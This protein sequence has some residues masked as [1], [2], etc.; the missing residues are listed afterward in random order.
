M[1]HAEVKRL[2]QAKHNQGIAM[3][4]VVLSAA[5]FL[6]ILL[7]VTTTL[8]ISSRRTTSDQRVTLEA[9]YASES[10]L[11]RVLNEINATTPQGDLRA[12]A[13]LI[14]SVNMS[15]I[16]ATALAQ[17]A[18]QFC[19]Y[20][21]TTDVPNHTT[22]LASV[23]STGFCT[24]NTDP[25]L[26]NRFAFLSAN[27]PT[28]SYATYLGASTF[29]VGGTAPTDTASAET[30]WQ[31][32]FDKGVGVKHSSVLNSSDTTSSYDVQFGLVPDR[33]DVSSSG[34]QFNFVFKPS[35]IR[36]I[37]RVAN[38]AT[39]LGERTST[40][41]LDGEFQIQVQPASFSFY[42]LLTD[43]Q[44]TGGPSGND[45]YF[46]SDTLYDGP[47]HTNGHFNYTGKPWFASN[48]T[49]AGCPNGYA[50][51]ANGQC[52]TPTAGAN[53]FNSGAA[54]FLNGNP[55]DFDGQGS[56]SFPQTVR[57]NPTSPP[58]TTAS[59]YTY[60]GKYDNRAIP[61]PSDSDRQKLAA[62]GLA[63]SAT[64]PVTGSGIYIPVVKTSPTPGQTTDLNRIYMAAVKSDGTPIAANP[65]GRAASAYQFIR[66]TRQQLLSNC[67]AKPTLTMTPSTPTPIYT[68]NSLSISVAVA[69]TT[70]TYT[71]AAAVQ[72]VTWS[73]PAGL[74]TLTGST[75]LT[76]TYKASAVPTVATVQATHQY[77]LSESKTLTITVT[78]APPPAPTPPT[79]PGLPTPP[80]PPTPPPPGP[81][82]TP[83]PPTPPSP[84]ASPPG[85]P[86]AGTCLYGPAVEYKWPM[87]DEY[88]SYKS[89]SQ[90]VLQKRTYPDTDAT[91]DNAMVRPAF[92][93]ASTWTNDTSDFN[94][95]IYVDGDNI[96]QIR[97]PSRGTATNP[98][99]ASPAVASF[100]KLNIVATGSIGIYN[101]L[102]YEKP[103]CYA[104]GSR[105]SYAVRN[106]D[107]S[108]TSAFCDDPKSPSLADN[109]LGIY[110]AGNNSDVKILR[111][112]QYQDFTINAVLMSAKG[113]VLV[114]GADAAT[115][116]T[117][118]A[119]G[120][121]SIR[122][123]GGIIQ[124][125]YGMW[126]RANASGNVDCG[127]GR[128]ITYD[129]RMASPLIT[130]PAFPTTSGASAL[131]VQ[132][133]RKG[134]S[135]QP[136]QQIDTSGTTVNSVLPVTI[137]AKQTTP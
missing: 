14:S 112:T 11:S 48:L 21:N 116:P 113:R 27:V 74:G 35:P 25:N 82:P 50:P 4:V 5:V 100:A 111:N 105:Q 97:G 109:I 53:V 95:V 137:G 115:C 8:S 120:R 1:I 67:P 54:A 121:G 88:R 93:D 24:P 32:V 104:S 125:N 132:F 37:G 71:E 119:G 42:A 38:G 84:P 128:S 90:M 107:N 7:A 39:V 22:S 79:P 31:A 76:T 86:I 12:W 16:D 63:T 58:A 51:T 72:Q 78:V 91:P 122:L 130:P 85:L 87:Y 134:Q 75:A 33:V 47:V 114:D 41:Q 101:D 45:V 127:Y 15:G 99:T 9:Q 28:T 133:F 124:K 59:A 80:T 106:P 40:A 118:L 26:S 29:K 126:G 55:P 69:P 61:L 108:V 3:I 70:N 117:E 10:G 98:D 30:Y 92:T 44:N 57:D 136:D 73:K 62:R 103:L 102:K 23:T 43:S 34:Q 65:S 135:G 49:S 17:L 123:L 52:G 2:K 77:D 18:A 129:R 19:N 64:P 110:T 36:S 20:A 83:P 13:G 68:G 96:P 89:G 46:S 94:G 81:T 6:S 131:L 56:A 60:K 66:I